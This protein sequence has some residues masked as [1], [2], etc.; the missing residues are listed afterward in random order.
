MGRVAGTRRR[1]PSAR[2]VRLGPLGLQPQASSPPRPH[3][4]PASGSQARHPGSASSGLS[5]HPRRLQDTQASRSSLTHSKPDAGEWLS[6]L[7]PASPHNSTLVSTSVNRGG[8]DP[9]RPSNEH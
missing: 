9:K 5:A 8:P 1:A 3:T 6:P 7:H 2:Q 4:R